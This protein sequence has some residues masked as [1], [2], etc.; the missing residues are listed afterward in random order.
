MPEEL[1]RLHHPKHVWQLSGFLHREP[2]RG[3]SGVTK[4]VV[5]VDGNKVPVVDM[6]YDAADDAMLLIAGGRHG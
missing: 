5:V 6:E 2:N 3:F 1:N 4:V